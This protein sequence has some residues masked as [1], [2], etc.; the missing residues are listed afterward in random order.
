MMRQN[1]NVALTLR[2]FRH[3]RQ[4]EKHKEGLE[5]NF[6]KSGSWLDIRQRGE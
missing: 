4:P 1:K 6:G 5:A 3:F 2:M